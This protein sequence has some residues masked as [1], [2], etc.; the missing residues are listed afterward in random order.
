MPNNTVPPVHCHYLIPTLTLSPSLYNHKQNN[1]TATPPQHH[2]LTTPPP[3]AKQRPSS[4]LYRRRH[5]NLMVS[6]HN[7]PADTHMFSG[8]YRGCT[9][10]SVSAATVFPESK[11]FLKTVAATLCVLGF[12]LVR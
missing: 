12:W 1:A 3:P 5:H 2:H 8:D 7:K 4:S 9:S 11:G 6:G 10:L